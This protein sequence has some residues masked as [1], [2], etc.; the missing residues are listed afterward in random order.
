MK[1]FKLYKKMLKHHLYFKH[2]VV[3]HYTYT[4]HCTQSQG[5]NERTTGITSFVTYK[6]F[7]CIGFFEKFSYFYTLQLPL[8]LRNKFGTVRFSPL[9]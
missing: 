3:H 5:P 9:V 1:K 2:L 6:F 4:H 8:N 7:N